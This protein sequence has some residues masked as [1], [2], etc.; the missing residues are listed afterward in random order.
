MAAE[1][2]LR[3]IVNALGSPCDLIVRDGRIAAVE[4]AGAGEADAGGLDRFL[5]S[6]LFDLQHNGCLGR[7]FNNPKLTLEE[8]RERRRFLLRHGVAWLLPTLITAPL[9]RLS[10][11]LANLS[12]HRAADAGLA[13]MIPGFHVEGP[14][15]SP[16]D[17]YRG[18]HN[19]DWIIEPK[20]D[21]FRRLQD[22]AGGLIR[23][24]TLA[25]ERPGAIPFIEKVAASGVIVSLAH[26]NPSDAVVRAAVAAGAGMVTHLGNGMASTIHRHANPLWSYLAEDRLA[27]GLI[28]DGFHVPDPLLR[29]ALAAKGRQAFLVSDASDLSGL[30]PGTYP[31]EYQELLIE[32]DGRLGVKGTEYL[33]GA[34]FQLDHCV[35]RAA[36]QLDWSRAQAWRMGSAEPARITGLPCGEPLRVGGPADVV[37]ARWDDRLEIERVILGGV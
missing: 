31:Y 36:R 28:A 37:V 23:I 8:L 26:C 29:T 3:G 30:P 1:L 13:A 33:A 22:A 6:P 32:P 11:A 27:C 9:D 24:L 20:F 19:R 14:W 10:A 18:A 16:E 25:P 2:A 21:D 35:D 12:A 7:A 5:L 15:I 34:W 17:G 4:P